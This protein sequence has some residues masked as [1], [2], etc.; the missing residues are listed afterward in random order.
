[1]TP[2]S[3]RRAVVSGLIWCLLSVS[4]HAA[5]IIVVN[6]NDPGVGFNDPTPA[7]PIGGNAGITVGQQRLVAFKYAA[8]IWGAALGGTV[9]IPVSATFEP[10][11]CGP[12]SGVLG[13]AGPVTIQLNAGAPMLP[14]TWYPGA[15]ANQLIGR[16]LDAPSP[17]IQAAFNSIVGGA[18]CLTGASW[19]Y[20]LDANHGAATNLDLAA[21]VLHELAHG[22]GFIAIDDT[23]TGRRCCPDLGTVQ[24]DIWETLLYDLS[25]GKHWV[26][27]TNAERAASAINARKLVW[28]G[29]NVKTA[30]PTILQLGTPS[31]TVSQPLS[32][33][34]EYLVGEAQF[35]PPIGSTAVS[36]ALQADPSSARDGCTAPLA[37]FAGKIALLDRGNC[38]FTVK[39]KNAQAAGALAVVVADNVA[40]SPPALMGGSDPTIT[41]PS[42]RVTQA[43]G[44][45]LRNALVSGPVMVSLRLL[46]V[47]AGADDQN[48]AML[49]SPNPFL[50]G[51]S[52]AH[53]EPS[54]KPALLLDPSYDTSLAHNLD[55]TSY[56]LRDIGWPVTNFAPLAQSADLA[57]VASGPSS[58]HTGSNVSYSVTVTNNGP[59]TAPDVQVFGTPPPGTTFAS[60][61]GDCTDFPCSLGSVAAG[62]SKTFTATYSVP[63]S[64]SAKDPIQLALNAIAPVPD[65]VLSNNLVTISTPLAGGGKSGGCGTTALPGGPMALAGLLCL[66]AL[67]RR[68][69]TPLRTNGVRN[70]LRTNGS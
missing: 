44:A 1:M 14:N 42:V 62:V 24:P 26:D 60:N 48:R 34:G 29:A 27:M 45:T 51:S 20:G 5:P 12:T 43:D 64:Y 37:S 11:T 49:Y 3:C 10:L 13:R 70:P 67:R 30:V 8:V 32:I 18:S 2:P 58:F 65:P 25:S 47:R 35:G 68:P 63:S 50:L 17:S 59:S 7:T 9:P 19:Y 41:I 66:V 53:F 46:P 36:G 40:G 31:L 69:S 22:L 55:L 6:N 16:D 52:V 61:T 15:L 4:S 57:I 39:V 54:S 21:V 23:L 38:N 28:D 56:L 33:K